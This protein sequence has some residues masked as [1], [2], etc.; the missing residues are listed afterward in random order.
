MVDSVANIL[1]IQ[2]PASAKGDGITQDEIAKIR[3]LFGIWNAHL[4]HN[5]EKSA[6]YNAEINVQNLQLAFKDDQ[7][8]RVV[9]PSVSWAAKAVDMLAE[10]SQLDFYAFPSDKNGTQALLKTL[11]ASNDL[12]NLYRQATISE[13]IHGCAC[14]TVTRGD[15]IY[16]EPQAVVNVYSALNSA[17]KWNMRHKSVEYGMTITKTD[18]DGTLTGINLFTADEVLSLSRDDNTWT[19]T[20]YLHNMQRPLIEPI[21]Y[22]P[23]IDNPLG[24]SRISRTVRSIINNALREDLRAEISAEI[25]TVPQRYFL[26]VD[27]DQLKDNFK[28]YWNSYFLLSGDVDGESAPTAGQFSP[29]GIQEH[30]SYKRALAAEFAGETGIPLSSLGITTDNPASAEAIMAAREDLIRQA[31]YLNQCNRPHM[32]NIAR[33]MYAVAANKTYTEA[34]AELA[35]VFPYFKRTDMPS[36]AAIA[37]MALKEV[38]SIPEL[39]ETRT[40]LRQL[41]PDDAELTVLLDE[42]K[43]TRESKATDN[44]INQIANSVSAK[45]KHASQGPDET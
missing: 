20:R 41:F 30:L 17:L 9:S 29:P 37:D 15:S 8:A 10:R 19:A 35:G 13:L 1:A 2:A 36:R 6:Y 32:L 40:F 28:T 24:K 5:Q 16:G 3:E 33:L 18:A 43:T 44:L 34:C 31:E 14:F 45:E 4:M 38:Q 23:T 26:N 7:V 27:T 12:D 11:Y 21:V 39:S 25:F 22:A 42:L